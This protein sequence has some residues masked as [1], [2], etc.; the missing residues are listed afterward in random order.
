MLASA[1]RVS[2]FE[3]TCRYFLLDDDL[4]FLEFDSVR[5]EHVQHPTSCVRALKFLQDVLESGARQL[6]R[7]AVYSRVCNVCRVQAA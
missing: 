2:S 3:H 1:G 7:I 5:G 6:L 4:N